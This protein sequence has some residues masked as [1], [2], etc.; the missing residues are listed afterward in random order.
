MVNYRSMI[1]AFFFVGII[2]LFSIGDFAQFSKK[3]YSTN[4]TNSSNED[5]FTLKKEDIL[6]SGNLSSG[7]IEIVCP[8]GP[9][10][11]CYICDEEIC[12]PI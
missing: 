9:D 4:L 12:R 10:D 6:K 11:P 8:S 1:I 3:S 2:V 7:S 5:F